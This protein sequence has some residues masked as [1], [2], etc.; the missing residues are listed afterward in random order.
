MRVGAHLILNLM[1]I[2]S[3]VSNLET[4]QLELSSI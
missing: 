3:E 4:P 1:A 2:S